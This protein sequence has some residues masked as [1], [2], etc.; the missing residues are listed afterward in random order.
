M[1]HHSRWLIGMIAGL[2]LLLSPAR[3]PARILESP[4]NNSTVS[5]LGFISGWKC[6]AEGDITARIDS[7][8][9]IP[10]AAQQSRA[11]TRPACGTDDN[12]FITQI[13]WNLLTDGPHSVGVYDNEV[14]FARSTFTV[15]NFGQEFVREA[16]GECTIEDFPV[17][18]ETATFAWNE[19]TQHLELAEIMGAPEDPET[20]ELDLA[21]FDG[22]WT[23]RFRLTS[24]GCPLDINL[25]ATCVISNGSLTCPN[26]VEGTIV[27]SAGSSSWSVD[28]V[29]GLLEGEF[30]GVLDD[31]IGSG[32]WDVL[33]CTGTWTLAKQDD[34]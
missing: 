31:Q 19:S 6:E 7:A 25:D 10:L 23:A 15:V 2:V 18:G 20:I 14:E 12:G 34:A 11:D 4:A 5:G 17:T 8:D 21:Q 29:L 3:A 13:N 30:N 24:S 27:F 16:T 33:G 32:S 26:G 22:T 9:H 28:G 1:R